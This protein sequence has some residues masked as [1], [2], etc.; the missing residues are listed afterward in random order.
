MF[1]IT[2]NL[3]SS[4]A[5][6]VL[7]LN[8]KDKNEFY[9]SKKKGE[10]KTAN[11]RKLPK[12]SKKWNGYGGKWEDVDETIFH[13]AARELKEESGIVAEVEDLQPVSRVEF[14]W[15]GNM[16]T[17]RDIEVFFF[18]VS[19]YKGIPSA[20]KTMEQPKLFTIKNAPFEEMMPADGLII[21]NIM[22]SKFVLGRIYFAKANNKLVVD[23]ALLSIQER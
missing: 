7:T 18:L 23:E 2:S 22:R 6:V 21:S 11:N 1:E 13:T 19:K 16:T 3:D 9:L 15:P 17:R 12:S 4:F 10:I 14:F 8:K 20:S 5:T